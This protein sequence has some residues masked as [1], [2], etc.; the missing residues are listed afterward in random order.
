MNF[1][2]HAYLSGDNPKLMVGN[3]IGDFVKGKQY[4]VFETDI[5]KG[6]LLHRLIDEYT[7]NHEIVLKSKKRLRKKYRH[8]SGVIVDVAYDH[9]LAKNWSTYSNTGLLEFTL[10]V[11]KTLDDHNS[12]LPERMRFMLGYMKRDNWLFHY[13]KLEGINRALT[14][15]S[16]RTKFDSKMEQA[17]EDIKKDYNLFFE[18][19]SEFFPDI[20]EYVRQ[21]IKA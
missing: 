10:D 11:Y 15:M 14:G 12:I 9:F 20:Q 2:A 19:F 5:A 18:E 13:S 7:D 17:V 1:L 16:K 3:F 21:Q 4:E 8:Y 6:V